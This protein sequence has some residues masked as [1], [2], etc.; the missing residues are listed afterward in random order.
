MPCFD[1][2]EHDLYVG[3][4]KFVPRCIGDGAQLGFDSSRVIASCL[5]QRLANPFLDGHSL[6]PGNALNLQILFII[7][8]DLEA[9]SHTD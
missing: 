2:P 8:E 4:W 1:L 6:P 3:R 9:F 7:Q 5:A